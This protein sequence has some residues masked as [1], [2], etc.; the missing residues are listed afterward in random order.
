MPGEVFIGLAIGTSFLPCILSTGA[1]RFSVV[2]QIW[3]TYPSHPF[4]LTPQSS[5]LLF[6][7]PGNI[8]TSHLRAADSGGARSTSQPCAA[9]YLPELPGAS[10]GT[11]VSSRNG[12]FVTPILSVTF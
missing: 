8:S 12:P 7:Q 2:D 1:A 3:L 9:V 5:P 11:E 4:P 10:E 6:S